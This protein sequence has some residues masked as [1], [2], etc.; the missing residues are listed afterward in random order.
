MVYS[1]DELTLR[2]QNLGEIN[3]NL[4]QFLENCE[5]C[6]P[7]EVRGSDSSSHEVSKDGFK[8]KL[9]KKHNTYLGRFNCLMWPRV[10]WKRKLPAMQPVHPLQGCRINNRFISMQIVGS[11]AVL[12][13]ATT[14]SIKL[15]KIWLCVCG[16][17]K[18]MLKPSDENKPSTGNSYKMHCLVFIGPSRRQDNVNPHLVKQ[19]RRMSSGCDSSHCRSSTL[20]DKGTRQ[21]SEAVSKLL[22]SLW[23]MRNG[24]CSHQGR[25]LQGCEENG[26]WHLW[27]LAQTGSLV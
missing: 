10:A 25:K 18:A 5:G 20:M 14:I 12:I 6:W 15:Q 1:W 3:L 19:S 24:W 22:C 27:K 9:V 4:G 21:G 17:Q 11:A 7:I 13:P 26:L 8:L 23:D 16:I 2:K